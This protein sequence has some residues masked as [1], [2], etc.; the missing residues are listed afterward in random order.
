MGLLFGILFFGC[1]FADALWFAVLRL[2]VLIVDEDAE[3]RP[4]RPGRPVA[5]DT[6][7]IAPPRPWTAT[8]Q[9][10]ACVGAEIDSRAAGQALKG[11][12]GLW[13]SVLRPAN[14]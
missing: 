10:A 2:A 8:G 1:T 9:Q 12:C 14:Q 6:R 7:D 13:W 5:R 3:C 4:S 11:R